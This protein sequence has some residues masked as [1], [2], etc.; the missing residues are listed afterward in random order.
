MSLRSVEFPTRDASLREDVRLLGD[1]VGQ[2]IREQGGDELFGRVE[3]ARHAAIRRREGDSDA[4]RDLEALLRGLSTDEAAEVV[5]AFSTY[6]QVVNLAERVHRIRRGRARMRAGAD[7][8]GSLTDTV[9][10]LADEGLD[11]EQAVSLF[12]R[13]RVE[14][15]FTAHPTEPTRRTILRKELRNR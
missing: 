4:E 15:V 5:R 7:Q 11:P 12:S 6:F 9:R 14:P 1:L 13:A 8:S 10:S 2:V 3:S